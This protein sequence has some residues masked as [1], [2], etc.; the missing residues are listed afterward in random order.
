PT[1]D[2]FCATMLRD[3]EHDAVR[4]YLLFDDK[5]EGLA[6]LYCPVKDGVVSY[7]HLGYVAEHHLN[8]HS[9]G[10]ILLWLVM[11]TLQ[12]EGSY[13]WFDFT[14]GSDEKST[15]QKSRFGTDSVQCADVWV[16]PRNLRYAMLLHVHRFVDAF[17]ETTGAALERF[18]IKQRV[19]HWMRR[20]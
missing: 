20:R 9:P 7:Q 1:S 4:A 18:G 11:Q 6:Y 2:S 3:A 17:S 16:F 14:E 15:G 10:T 5:G 8:R 19:K 12:E 13:R